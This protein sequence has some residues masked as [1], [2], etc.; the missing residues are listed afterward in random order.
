MEQ[1]YRPRM[2]RIFTMKQAYQQASRDVEDQ[3]VVGNSTSSF[4][5]QP[6]MF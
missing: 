2:G 4:I 1:G 5:M 3:S 6:M